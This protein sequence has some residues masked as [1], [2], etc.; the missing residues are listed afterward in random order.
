MPRSGKRRF[1]VIGSKA[2]YPS[3]TFSLE[4]YFVLQAYFLE[5]IQIFTTTTQ[6]ERYKKV[7][8]CQQGSQVDDGRVSLLFISVKADS[9]VFTFAG[10][11]NVQRLQM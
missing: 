5:K 8:V 7:C 6:K 10:L 9:S 11:E 4:T 2:T 3:Q 1:D